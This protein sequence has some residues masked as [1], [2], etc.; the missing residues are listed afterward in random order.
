MTAR[1]AAILITA[2]ELS[3]WAHE[4][5]H[6]AAS[7]FL[8]YGCESVDL[9]SAHPSV[10]T[11]RP[12]TAAH[13]ALIRNAGWLASVAI[14]GIG[15]TWAWKA[16]K[17]W[18][19]ASEPMVIIV[20]ALLY[21]AA[22]AVHS[23]LLASFRPLGRYFCGNFG[24]ILFQQASAGNVDAFLRRMLQVT[25][26]RGAQSAGFVTYKRVHPD[27]VDC[28]GHRNR[29]V[30]GKRTDLSEKLMDKS[31]AVTRP[32][33]ICAPQLFQ[34]HTRFATSSIAD[35]SGTHPHQW[36]PRST[37][38]YWQDDAGWPGLCVIKV[39]AGRLNRMSHQ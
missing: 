34:G 30:N 20:A 2:R 9:C 35:F 4:L 21:S 11:A 39:Q 25:M 17:D 18:T 10:T 27:R 22:E 23:D 29:V 3:L 8:G 6:A 38:T 31:R 19:E 28:V 7:T 24:L 1:G 36:S 33:A 13:D 12:P 15:G 32:K 14:A 16:I 37:Q 26:M 5:A